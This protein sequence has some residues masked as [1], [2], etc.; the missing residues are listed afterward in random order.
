MTSHDVVQVVRR[1]T[2]VRRVGHGGTLDPAVAGVLP[3]LVGRATRL[4][5][6]LSEAAKAY[7]AQIGFGKTTHTQDA[8]GETLNEQ[9][10]PTL[11]AEQ[12]QGALTAFH[13]TVSQTPPMVSAVKV[14]GQ[15]LYELARQ[16]VEVARPARQVTFYELKLLGFEPGDFPS[17]YLDVR[18]SK[19]TYI[20]TLA[21][22]LGAA[23]GVGGY[24]IYLVRTAS[25]GFELSESVTLEEL[26]E[27]KEA[28]R[29][30]QYLQPLS[31][32]VAHLPAC[33]LPAAVASRVRHGVSPRL[34]AAL[35]HL[36]EGQPVACFDREQDEL[37]AIGQRQ[38]GVLRLTKVFS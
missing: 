11:T 34:P 19:G 24:L 35:A 17:A 14:G 32:A 8:W 13:G 23:L 6:F 12:V 3:I 30:G 38:A 16:G 4:A 5:E 2:G 10:C 18:C 26:A 36:P 33:H 27:A 20:R 9:P 29:L 31:R 28:G 7:R 1:L 25:G 37:L 22:D 21:A 15:R